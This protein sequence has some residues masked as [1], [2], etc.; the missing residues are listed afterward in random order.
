MEEQ[1]K[2]S[3]L[4]PKL[5]VVLLPT[6]AEQQ[7]LLSSETGRLSKNFL[8]HGNESDQSHTKLP[9]ESKLNPVHSV[10]AQGF[11]A[12]RFPDKELHEQLTTSS[13]KDL[14]R[15]AP[16]TFKIKTGS[17][18]HTISGVPD[19]FKPYLER[20]LNQNALTYIPH[21][22]RDTV[23]AFYF[24]ESAANALFGTGPGQNR[25]TEVSILSPTHMQ[26]AFSQKGFRNYNN[27]QF[28]AIPDLESKFTLTLDLQIDGEMPLSNEDI[29]TLSDDPTEQEKIR[30]A[31]RVKVSLNSVGFT[32][33][34]DPDKKD[35][36]LG[37]VRKVIAFH[38]DILN[39]GFNRFIGKQNK[40]GPKVEPSTKIVDWL[41][42]ALS[43]VEPRLVNNA[44]TKAAYQYLPPYQNSVTVKPKDKKGEKVTQTFFKKADGEIYSYTS[45][46][47]ENYF[48]TLEKYLKGNHPNP[49]VVSCMDIL[50]ALTA[51]SGLLNRQIVI[52]FLE[53]AH[54]N[55]FES[56]KLAIAALREQANQPHFTQDKDHALALLA[57][58][59]AQLTAVANSI[60]KDTTPQQLD[61]ALQAIDFSELNTIFK[62][63]VETV[64][65]EKTVFELYMEKNP[66]ARPPKDDADISKLLARGLNDKDL[67][68]LIANLFV[69]GKLSLID[70]LPRLSRKNQ[71]VLLMATLQKCLE[72]SNFECFSGLDPASVTPAFFDAFASLDGN[73]ANKLFDHLHTSAFKEIFQGKEP[74][75]QNILAKMAARANRPGMLSR[76]VN[77][78]RYRALTTTTPVLTVAKALQ[79]NEENAIQRLEDLPYA[80][81]KLLLGSKAFIQWIAERPEADQTATSHAFLANLSVVG[82]SEINRLF[83]QIS[84][85]TKDAAL[86]AKILGFKKHASNLASQ[87][88]LNTPAYQ[89]FLAGNPRN[90]SNLGAHKLGELAA[91]DASGVAL[92]KL[93]EGASQPKKTPWFWERWIQRFYVTQTIAD[94]R[95]ITLQEKALERA[96]TKLTHQFFATSAYEKLDDTHKQML[97]T[98]IDSQSGHHKARLKGYVAEINKKLAE[99]A[100]QAAVKEIEPHVVAPTPV[101]ATSHYT[102]ITGTL[103]DSPSPSP[104]PSPREG[105]VESGS[106]TSS[107]RKTVDAIKGVAPPSPAKGFTP[108]SSQSAPNLGAIG[109]GPKAKKKLEFVDDKGKDEASDLPNNKAES[110]GGKTPTRH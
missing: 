42:G 40:P 48:L 70:E 43:P 8:Q 50:D 63:H 17:V 97:T 7:V 68:V 94:N 83:S 104:S 82:K 44:K 74:V 87:D 4:P 65:G 57:E 54:E 75:T 37:Q 61:E 85:S 30:N 98:Y 73:S 6:T 62:N 53:N 56:T 11:S 64:L 9:A 45:N 80:N 5:N 29:A 90:I 77:K 76:R 34:G 72:L 100:Q 96:M 20:H 86:E 84:S 60:T 1:R 35:Q 16:F 49:E 88:I 71:T 102:G 28:V 95:F 46:L 15:G 18:Q 31:A 66:D 69:S 10:L 110:A 92:G 81:K 101:A 14:P 41:S 47:K 21:S 55:A 33:F 26:V 23:L 103:V 36:A 78:E 109:G 51:I 22:Y 3:Q 52:H 99:A 59:E 25:K 89:E 24:T 39:V 108:S 2:H 13:H 38:Q 106:P 19:A 58:L 107:L 32:L 91:A 93:I 79:N 27:P 105:L 12:N 67:H